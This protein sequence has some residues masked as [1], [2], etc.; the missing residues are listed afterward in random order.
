M[1]NKKTAKNIFIDAL[2]VLALNVLVN[3]SVSARENLVANK[4]YGWYCVPAKDNAQPSFDIN[5]DD[6]KNYGAYAIGDKDDKV[7]YLTFDFGYENGNVKKCL[8]VLNKHG[9]KGAFFILENVIK[10]NP[11]L[12]KE[13][14][15][16]PLM[17]VIINVKI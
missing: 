9:V 15:A 5:L 11:E 6:M 13:M 16:F 10:T 3:I 2:A 12:M 7:L 4:N 8:D 14:A 1:K 17:N